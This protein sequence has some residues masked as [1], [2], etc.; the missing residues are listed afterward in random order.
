MHA[1]RLF[2]WVMGFGPAIAW[3][4][5]AMLHFG[6]SRGYWLALPFVLA[7]ALGIFGLTGLFVAYFPAALD[8]LGLRRFSAWLRT[9][10]DDDA[11]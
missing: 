5:F 7:V 11:R 10:W 1:R 4:V 3:V 2:S 6:P 9:W 8:R